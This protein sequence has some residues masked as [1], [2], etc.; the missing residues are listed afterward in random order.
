MI[1]RREFLVGALAASLYPKLVV[2]G[3]GSSR[4]AVIFSGHTSLPGNEG[5]LSC[6]GKRER[7]YNDAVLK[8]M[9]QQTPSGLE[10]LF[11]PATENL[12]LK[13]RPVLARQKGAELYLEIHHDSLFQGHLD[14]M[15]GVPAGDPRWNDFSGFSLHYSAGKEYGKQSFRFAQLLGEEMKKVLPSDTYHH[16]YERMPLADP[17]RAIYRR[18]LYVNEH[19]SMPSVVLECGYIINPREEAFLSQQDT[20]RKIAKA[21]SEA[22]QNYFK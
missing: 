8:E 14:Q 9:Q 21:I 5:A 4:K 11:F 6:T 1:S 10:C 19:A 7:Y 22:L 16:R 13:Q 20:R 2:A 17:E 12:P 3:L 15:K 18:H